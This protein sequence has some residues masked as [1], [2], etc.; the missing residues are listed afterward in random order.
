MDY[1]GYVFR[2]FRGDDTVGV[3]CATS[4]FDAE[5]CVRRFYSKVADDIDWTTL[6]IKPL[7]PHNAVCALYYG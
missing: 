3:V 5:Q 7:D 2:D 6:Q 4:V 1:F